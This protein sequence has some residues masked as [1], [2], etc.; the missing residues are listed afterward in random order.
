MIKQLPKLLMLK[1]YLTVFGLVKKFIKNKHLRQALSIQPLLLGGNPTST[2]SIYNL[3]HFLERKWGV[4]YAIGGTG[5]LIK[6]L[7]KLM[8]EEKIKIFLNSEITNLITKKNEVIGVEVKKSKKYYA[9]KIVINADPAFTYKNLLKTNYNKKWNYRKIKKLDFSMGL[10][11]LY[12]GTKKRY[13]DIPHHTIWMGKR[14][15]SLLD[16]IFEKKNFS[17]GF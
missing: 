12:F 2:T 10:F 15:E 17:K 7:H 3:I 4:H 6:A 8:K 1:S 16:D 13:N 11:V 14:Y 9:D 5:N